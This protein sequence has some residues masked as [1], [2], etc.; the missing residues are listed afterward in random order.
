MAQQGARD[1]RGADDGDMGTS[2]RPRGKL[3]IEELVST[4]G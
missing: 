4:C 2:A 3:T 1:G